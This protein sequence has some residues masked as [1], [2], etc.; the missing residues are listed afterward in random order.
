VVGGMFN[1]AS[2]PHIRNTIFW[3]NTGAEIYNT[4]SSSP[5]VSDSVVEGGCPARSICTHII[6]TDPLLGTLGNYGGSTQTI[7]LQAGSSAIDT[8]NDGVCPATDQR[9]VFRPQGA[10]CDIGSYEYESDTIPPTVVSI[11][12]AD[13][14]PTNLASVD[15]TVTFSETVTGVDASDFSL[16]TTGTLSGT[17]VT[18]MSGLG[19]TYTVTVG[20]GSGTGTLRLDVTDEDSIVDMAGNPL[21]GTGAGNGNFSGGETYDVRFHR[22]YLPLV[23][24]NQP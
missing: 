8:G 2:S 1:D 23:L 11:T 17:L 10:H 22:I 12:R 14:N 6:S 7:P 24:R 3:G 4:T 13:A 20:T 21:G 19:T 5:V 15:F 9:G 16:T 18:G